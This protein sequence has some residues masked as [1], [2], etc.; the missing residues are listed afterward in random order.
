MLWLKRDLSLRGKDP[1][2]EAL[3][4]LHVHRQS[5]SQAVTV[6]AEG[7]VTFLKSGEFSAGGGEL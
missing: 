1:S 6:R 3:P 5:L 7:I 4:F 2:F